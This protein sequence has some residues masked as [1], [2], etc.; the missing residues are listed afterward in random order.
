MKQYILRKA[1]IHIFNHGIH[2][3]NAKESK[4]PKKVLNS[5]DSNEFYIFSFSLRDSSLSNFQTPVFW[6]II[7]KS[8]KKKRIFLTKKLVTEKKSEYKPNN[9]EYLLEL[10]F[11]V[12]GWQ[13]F[14]Y[15]T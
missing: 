8:M 5:N 3:E 6:I 13:E 15:K 9:E 14:R 7:H 1:Q 12:L 11:S 2:N 4:S 10:T